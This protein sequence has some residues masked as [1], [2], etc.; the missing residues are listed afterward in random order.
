MSFH[1]KLPLFTGVIEFESRTHSSFVYVI[2]LQQFLFAVSPMASLPKMAAS[3]SHDPFTPLGFK[4][5]SHV[6]SAMSHH[7][8][9]TP[10]TNSSHKI[11][12]GF[13]FIVLVVLIQLF[14]RMSEC[15]I[16][17]I[18]SAI[19]EEL[20]P[21]AFQFHAF[22]DN[23]ILI[24]VVSEEAFL[25]RAFS[26]RPLQRTFLFQAAR[27]THFRVDG[28]MRKSAILGRAVAFEKIRA[29]LKFLLGGK[30]RAVI[31]RRRR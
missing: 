1:A 31:G 22:V 6:F 10:M 5:R 17:P 27:P 11:G 4:V 18:A 13:R 2:E 29:G 23:S 24:L 12:A 28:A 7:T 25:A 16:T 19:L 30:L 26:I 3:I 9:L 14:L 8:K 15:A 20:A 21:L